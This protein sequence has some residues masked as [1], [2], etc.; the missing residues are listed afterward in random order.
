[1]SQVERHK[2]LR[3]LVKKL[4]R[5]R[6]QQA[7]K[8]DILCHDLIAAQRQF[9]HKLNGVAFAAHFYKD[10]LGASDLRTVL[11]RAGRIIREELPGAEVAFFLRQSDRYE[12]HLVEGNRELDLA[13]VRLHECFTPELLDNVCKAN[14]PCT[15]EDLCGMGLLANPAE[16]ARLSVATLPLSDMGR[17]LGFI[18]ICRARQDALPREETEKIGLITCGLSRAVVGSCSVPLPAQ[19]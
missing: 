8:I 17:S 4:N 14:R 16:L 11:T 13:I 6:K 3:L 18:L 19:G 7:R 10:L 2:R 9:M 15:A 1:M 5:R 12:R